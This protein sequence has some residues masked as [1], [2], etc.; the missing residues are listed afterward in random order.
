MSRS[1]Y[2]DDCEDLALWR[3]AV[4][5]A[6]KGKRG[7]AALSDLAA[8]LDGMAVKQLSAGSFVAGGMCTLGALAVH[9]GVPT[10][11]IE[12]DEP[13]DWV[14]RDAVSQRF[15]IAPAMA[16]EIMYENDEYHGVETPQQRWDRMRRWIGANLAQSPQATEPKR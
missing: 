13:G 6:I 2:C 12:P 3:G 11:D 1:G 10:A 7:Q 14:D 4:A 9:R 5:R 8:A 15:N 16:A